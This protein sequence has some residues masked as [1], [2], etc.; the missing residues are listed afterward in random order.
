MNDLAPFLTRYL[1]GSAG[2]EEIHNDIDRWHSE[3]IPNAPELHEFLGLTPAEYA[4]L[5]EN[6]W[7][8]VRYLDHLKR[9]A[10]A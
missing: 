2:I 7:K 3:P 6:E 5:V 1:Y 8:F 9:E 4:I 10:S